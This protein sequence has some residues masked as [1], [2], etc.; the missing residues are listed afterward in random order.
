MAL[1]LK[2]LTGRFAST[3]FLLRLRSHGALRRSADRDRS[4]NTGGGQRCKSA[5]LCRAV[6]S[7][8]LSDYALCLA[9][10]YSARLRA[11]FWI[12]VSNFVLPVM[13]NV[14]QLIINFRDDNIFHGAYALLV[15]IYVEIISVLLATLWCSGTYWN[16]TM[17]VGHG[18][19][20]QEKPLSLEAGR[21]TESFGSVKFAEGPEV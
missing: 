5:S 4:V 18:S 17:Q 19:E 2:L 11:L 6:F 21:T 14:A 15:N 3:L 1:T 9:G 16:G 20:S 8:E 13:F 10:S 12:A 7:R